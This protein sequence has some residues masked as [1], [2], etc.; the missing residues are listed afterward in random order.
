MVHRSELQTPESEFDSLA[1]KLMQTFPKSLKYVALYPPDGYAT[2]DLS[3]LPSMPA[4]SDE[5]TT[6]SMPSSRKVNEARAYWRAIVKGRLERGELEGEPVKQKVGKQKKAK[7]GP[8]E[9]EAPEMA[10]DAQPGEESEEQ[11][12]DEPDMQEV[13]LDEDHKDDFFA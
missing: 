9:G 7:A 12:E 2:F 3:E 5:K 1:D 13:D 11:E 8:D 4:E 10:V 6:A